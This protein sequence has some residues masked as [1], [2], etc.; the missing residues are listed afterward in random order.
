MALAMALA[1][2]ART[3]ADFFVAMPSS[4]LPL[5]NDT[6][7]QDMVDYYRYGSDR[8]TDNTFRGKSRVIGESDV[9]LTVAVAENSQIE[10]AIIPAKSDTILAV[11]STVS[12]PMRDA[13]IDFYDRNWQ[14]LRRQPVAMP[15]FTDWIT[16]DGEAHL[17]DITLTL[18]FIP[19][20]ISYDAEASTLTFHNN[21]DEMLAA[22]DAERLRQWLHQ[23]I[24]YDIKGTKFRRRK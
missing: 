20:T 21:T 22:E 7:R 18:D 3:A 17:A 16:K 2:A 14:P 13:R 12:L 5:F 11:I 19:M 23:D 15:E 10:V 9:V 1:G 6:Q 8:S 24:I 4:V